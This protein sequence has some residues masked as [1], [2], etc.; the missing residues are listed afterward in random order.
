MSSNIRL[1]REEKAIQLEGISGNMVLPSIS[2]GKAPITVRTK[3]QSAKRLPTKAS[4]EKNS[5]QRSTKRIYKEEQVKEEQTHSK[6]IDLE[7]LLVKKQTILENS[8][9]K[10]SSIR[11]KIFSLKTPTKE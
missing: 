6:K 2:N 10:P 5:N 11:T 7:G 1:N 4:L 3:S 8:S 9:N